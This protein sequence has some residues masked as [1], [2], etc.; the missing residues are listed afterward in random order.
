MEPRSSAFL[1]S[2]SR[3]VWSSNSGASAATASRRGSSRSPTTKVLPAVAFQATIYVQVALSCLR[4]V[5]RHLG[6]GST[7]QHG[8]AAHRHTNQVLLEI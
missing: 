2:N 1:R 5:Q 4:L 6:F 7:S 8:D 3:A